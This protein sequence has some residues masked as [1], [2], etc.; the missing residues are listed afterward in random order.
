M[1]STSWIEVPRQPRYRAN[2]AGACLFSIRD[3]VGQEV[4]W[5]TSSP[6]RQVRPYQKEQDPDTNRSDKTRRISFPT[7]SRQSQPAVR[8]NAEFP[9]PWPRPM[10]AIFQI[11]PLDRPRLRRGRMQTQTA[12]L[13]EAITRRDLRGSGATGAYLVKKDGGLARPTRQVFS[14]SHITYLAHTYT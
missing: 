1:E 4:E 13:E 3:S 14:P 9:S 11:L 12:G 8:P 7:Q 2:Y 10:I 6:Q 5:T